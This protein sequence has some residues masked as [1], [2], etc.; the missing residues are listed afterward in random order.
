MVNKRKSKKRT[1]SRK[2]TSGISGMEHMM[3]NTT[4]SIGKAV[5]G[6]SAIGLAGSII[7]RI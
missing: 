7:G 4:E 5:V 3:E 6:L 2:D 1:T